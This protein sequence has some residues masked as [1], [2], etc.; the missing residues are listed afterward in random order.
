[1]TPAEIIEAITA[2][3]KE[4]MHQLRFM[5]HLN[6]RAIANNL[7]VHGVEDV[8]PADYLTL[9]P[10]PEK[11][12][13]VVAQDPKQRDFLIKLFAAVQERENRKHG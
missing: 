1:M 2:R 7:A 10:E 8:T 6:A 9:P 13:E 12:R 11:R 5:D 4:T 3:S